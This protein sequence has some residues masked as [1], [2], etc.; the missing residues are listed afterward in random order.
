M[1]VTTRELSLANLPATAHLML[2]SD[3]HLG[4]AFTD[5]DAIIADLE[6]ARRHNARI[7]LNG[8][9]F[10]AIVPSDKKRYNPT[11][12]HPKLRN[13]ADV[14]GACVDHARELLAPYADLIDVIGVRNH[15]TSSEKYHAVDPVSMLLY[16]LGGEARHGGY[17]GYYVMRGRYEKSTR[18]IWTLKVRYHHGSGGASP[19]TKGITDFQRMRSWI[20]DADVITVGHKHNKMVVPDQRERLS[21][22]GN[23]VYEPLLC[24]MTGAYLDTYR[25]QGNILT[26]GR[27]ANYTADWNVAPQP[28]G[29]VLLEIT[30]TASGSNKSLPGV[31]RQTPIVKAIL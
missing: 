8:D 24:V 5:E 28:K 30:F 23:V 16:A 21:N 1:V 20:S 26:E 10:D 6:T 18:A 22:S 29:G 2:M 27:Q 11:A 17:C 4:S 13:R 25:Q 12:I 7:L 3:L 15:E 9:V 19:V 14:L 31:N